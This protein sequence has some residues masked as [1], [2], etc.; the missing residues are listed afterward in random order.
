MRFFIGG[1]TFQRDAQTVSDSSKTTL[2]ESGKSSLSA[3]STT[4]LGTAGFQLILETTEFGTVGWMVT[5]AEFSLTSLAVSVSHLLTEGIF[6]F[7]SS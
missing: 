5:L 6:S 7:K 1:D 4:I 3:F 2:F